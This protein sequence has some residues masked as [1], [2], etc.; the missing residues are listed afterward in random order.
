MK[1]RATMALAAAA[2]L[3]ATVSGA[4]SAAGGP[5]FWVISSDDCGQI[6]TVDP[7]LIGSNVRFFRHELDACGQVRIEPVF[8]G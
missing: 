8:L 7:K 1:K 3:A 5:D 2:L 6:S 4:A